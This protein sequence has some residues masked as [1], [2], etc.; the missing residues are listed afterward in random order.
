M[1]RGLIIFVCSYTTIFCSSY[2]NI[3]NIWFWSNC[4]ISMYV[5]P[6]WPKTIHANLFALDISLLSINKYSAF[7]IFLQILAKISLPICSTIPQ[8]HEEIFCWRTFKK[9]DKIIKSFLLLSSFQ[10]CIITSI[11]QYPFFNFWL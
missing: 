11:L 6:R 8:Y 7:V 1:L 10:M 2:I 9:Y 4:E 3:Q 5:I